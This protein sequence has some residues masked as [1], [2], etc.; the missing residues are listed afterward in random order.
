MSAKAHH[1]PCSN[2]DFDFF[3]EG[4]E[5]E[6]VVVQ[7]C[8]R[9]GVL[10]NPPSPSCPECR[11]FEWEAFPLSRE[12]IVHSFTVHHHPPLP[13]FATPHP[14]VLA[15]MAEGI[16]LLGAMDGTA[17]EQIRIGMRLGFEFLRRDTVAAFRFRVA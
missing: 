5:R 2:Q 3:Y 16:R 6:Q 1:A 4:L 7:K 9:C 10:R 12:G 14:V 8:A 15:D 13:G 17:P 11:S